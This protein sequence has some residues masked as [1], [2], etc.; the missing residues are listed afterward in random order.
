MDLKIFVSVKF[1]NPDVQVTFS[2]KDAGLLLKNR[3]KL[4][5]AIKDVSLSYL[6][7]KVSMSSDTKILF[8]T[9]ADDKNKKSPK[10]TDKRAQKSNR[11]LGESKLQTMA[12]KAMQEVLEKQEGVQI[13]KLNPAERRMVHIYIE[14]Q[15]KFS[16]SSQ[17]DG[18]LK[19]IL[20]AQY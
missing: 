20:Y 13:K 6:R 12:D 11:N 8:R 18:Y 17:G 5:N 16:S 9:N 4:H 1:L 7:N 3:F 15:D 2:G 19:N 14:K 10:T